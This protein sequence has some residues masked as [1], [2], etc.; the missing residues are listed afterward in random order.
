MLDG[1]GLAARLVTSLERYQARLQTSDHGIKVH[2]SL[3]RTVGLVMEGVAFMSPSASAV[4][5]RAR[6]GGSCLP[7]WS[8]LTA[9]A[10]S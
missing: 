2:G 7:R 8:A 6:R 10:F 9:G 3:V 1:D 4:L 5:S